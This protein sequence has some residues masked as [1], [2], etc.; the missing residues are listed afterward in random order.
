MVATEFARGS[1]AVF[2]QLRPRLFAVAYRMTGTKADAEDIVQEA[3]LRWHRADTGEVRSAEAWLVSVTTRLSIDRLRRAS[4]ER[5]KYTGLW[6]PEPL[7]GAPPRPPDERLERD[8]DRSI[9]P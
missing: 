7:F 5:E 4:L 6:L 8:S 1:T 9:R 2:E 3:Y